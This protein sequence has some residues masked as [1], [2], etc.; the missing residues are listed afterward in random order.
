LD[1]TG[2]PENLTYFLNDGSIAVG[3]NQIP[4][5]PGA[6]IA[7]FTSQLIVDDPTDIS[8]I[9]GGDGVD[10]FHVYATKSAGILLNGQKGSDQYIFHLAAGDPIIKATVNDT[11]NPWDSGDT[12][13]VDG[14][15]GADVVRVTSTDLTLDAGQVTPQEVVTYTSPAADANVLQVK[16]NGN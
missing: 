8:T 16:V 14:S 3:F 15:S 1:F 12:I 4:G 10:T 6:S 5:T 2:K 9:K 13:K 7:D 11:G